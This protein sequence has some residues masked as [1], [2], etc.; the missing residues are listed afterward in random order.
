MPPSPQPEP[1]HA[2]PRWL[3]VLVRP[4]GDAAPH[5]S[6][7]TSGAQMFPI[8]LHAVDSAAE[9]EALAG[10][11]RSEGATVAVI[12][13]AREAPV[14]CAAHPP[15]LL[16]RTCADCGQGIC[17]QCRVEAGGERRCGVCAARR[18]AERRRWRTRQ[19]FTIFLF[20][21]FLY[22]VVQFTR[23]ERA[24]LDPEH[25]ISVAVFQLV[26][27]GE[28]DHPIVRALNA[29]DGP[30]GLLR[31]QDWYDNEYRRYTGS[32]R[33]L[34]HMRV[35]GPWTPEVRPPRLEEAGTSWWRLAYTSWAFTRYWPAL[36][37]PYGVDPD[38]WDVRVYLVYGHDA[39]DL[40][41]DSR[42]SQ[43]G[44]LAVPFISLDDPNPAYAQLTVAHEL[45]HVFGAEDLY[46]P[47]T[48]LA[49]LPL[50]LAEPNRQPPFP[51][52]YAEVMAADRPL[53]PTREVEVTSLDEV[54]VGYHS[55]S[56]MG[57]IEPETAA[58][59]YLPRR[60]VPFGPEC[61]PEPATAAEPGAPATA[62]AVEAGAAVAPGETPAE[63]PAAPTGQ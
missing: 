7:P 48:F 17:A 18:A 37:R 25:G 30:Y 24:H 5:P 33:P 44:R 63:A 41:A 58:L 15:Q 42:G 52:R 49:Q 54:R 36:V 28:V 31:V 29:V 10:K 16:G 39:G 22:E 56:L 35:F 9:A 26:P 40:A 55:A 4:T 45:G 13:E 23:S 32:T 38:R 46:D 6:I 19:L 8:L 50:G 27:P 62:T 60:D 21:V 2:G 20:V 14:T 1:P 53:S 3:V 57:W 59:H 61:A 47:Q 12:A 43:K 11:L 34:V 51:Q